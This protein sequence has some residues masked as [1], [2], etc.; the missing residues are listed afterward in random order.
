VI[1][2]LIYWVIENRKH[3]VSIT[4][5]QTAQSRENN[6]Y[7]QLLELSSNMIYPAHEAVWAII[8]YNYLKVQIVYIDCNLLLY[9]TTMWVNDV[10]HLSHV[11]CF[12]GQI[13]RRAAAAAV[14]TGSSVHLLITRCL[15]VPAMH[16]V[17]KFNVWRSG[18]A[19]PA[20][21]VCLPRATGRCPPR[22][23]SAARR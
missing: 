19:R 3:I 16:V 9:L 11:D 23:L 6:I 13:V 7:Y 4:W 17:R 14:I 21:L 22:S 15:N 2:W 5:L 20:R 1:D 8:F 18:L 10:L 12:D